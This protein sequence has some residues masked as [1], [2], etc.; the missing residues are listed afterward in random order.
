MTY[1]Q[2]RAR[3]T[4]LCF[5]RYL[6]KQSPT[7]AWRSAN[8]G[9]KCTD[10]SAAQLTRRE[11]AWLNEERAKERADPTRAFNLFATM[12]QNAASDPRPMTTDLETISEEPLG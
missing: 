1:E 7:E 2:R 4:W 10:A 11:I 5:Y 8:P 9:A 3:A 6:R 12:A